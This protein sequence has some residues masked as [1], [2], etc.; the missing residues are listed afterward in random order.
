[1]VR[2]VTVSAAAAGAARRTTHGR[3]AGARKGLISAPARQPT[4]LGAIVDAG[5]ETEEVDLYR[6]TALRYM[7]YANECGEAFADWLPVGGVPAS[8]AV[9]IAYVL[10]DTV[11]K[12]KKAWQS[13]ARPTECPPGDLDCELE[14]QIPDSLRFQH[15]ASSTFDTLAWQL[16]ASVFIPGSVIH[17]SVAACKAAVHVA[18]GSPALVDLAASMT[19]A[20]VDPDKTLPTLFG[21]AVIPFIVHPIDSTVHKVMDVSTRPALLS[22]VCG[23][24]GGE[25]AG[26]KECLVKAEDW[27]ED[28]APGAEILG[29]KADEVTAG[30]IATGAAA[31][32]AA[33]A[34]PPVMF[35]LSDVVFFPGV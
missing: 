19:A 25:A 17:L 11:D 23:A 14:E 22:M 12:S 15:A 20:G 24:G 9:A 30:G 29:N 35:Y 21:L 4:R 13:T 18:V 3:R 6:D 31:I 28:V 2:Q 16:L 33:C 7:G 8:Y 5:A 1:M 10:A 32:G 26:I 27:N 34:F